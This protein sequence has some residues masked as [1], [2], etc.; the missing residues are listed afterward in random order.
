MYSP[1][2]ARPLL[3]SGLG[4]DLGLFDFSSLGLVVLG[5]LAFFGFTGFFDKK[6][7]KRWVSGAYRSADYESP[8][9]DYGVRPKR[10]RAK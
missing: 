1:A 4:A 2:S 10:R 8:S 7:K 3:A 9:R 6:K 5:T